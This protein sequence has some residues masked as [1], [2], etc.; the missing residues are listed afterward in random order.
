MGTA[1]QINGRTLS[2]VKD[3]AKATSYSRGY[4][5]RLAREGKIVASNVGTRWFVDFESLCNYEEA[6]LLESAVRRNQLSEERRRERQLNTVA[7]KLSKRQSSQV[8]NLKVKSMTIGGLVLALG[9]L[10]GVTGYK[11]WGSDI[12]QSQ[13]NSI[14]AKGSANTAS[15]VD[16][17]LSNQAIPEV[18]VASGLVNAEYLVDEPKR[19]VSQMDGVDMYGLLLLPVIGDK[20]TSLLDNVF[21]DPVNIQHNSDGTYSVVWL[22][23]DGVESSHKIPFVL[24]P[25]ESEVGASDEYHNI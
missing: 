25:V 11:F 4:I 12:T 7:D 20:S 1:L 5:T 9:L 3:A 14:S 16:T 24:L 6:S 22:S 2:P 8:R 10:G 23:D 21:S 18:P 19:E 13:I 17:A 15:T